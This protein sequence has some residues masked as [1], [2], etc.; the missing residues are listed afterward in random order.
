MDAVIVYRTETQSY[1]SAIAMYCSKSHIDIYY[2]ARSEYIVIQIDD[3]I[4]CVDESIWQI[5]LCLIE[6]SVDRH[7]PEPYFVG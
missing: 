6:M 2:G 4:Y 5:G 3:I 7:F 1:S